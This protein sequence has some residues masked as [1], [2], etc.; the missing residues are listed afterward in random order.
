MQVNFIGHGL[1]KEKQINVGEQLT[2]SFESKIYDSFCGFIAFAAASGILKLLKSIE[3]AK[4]HYSR[5]TF[6]IGV[7]NKGTSKEALELLVQKEIEVYI[8]HRQEDYITYHPKLFL[9]EGK[10]HTRIILGS[11]NLTH[12][13]LIN[14][15]EASVQL[16]FQP[17]TDK[18]GKKVLTEVKNYFHDLLH[19]KSDNIFKL[20]NDLIEKY[21]KEG[22]LYSQFAK[23][24]EKE[25]QPTDGENNKPTD[26]VFIPEDII[27]ESGE[28]PNEKNY[29]NKPPVL[30]DTDFENFEIFL[31]QYVEYK[32][33]VNPTG[34][35]N[36]N[37]QFVENRQLVNWYDRIKELIRNDIL[38]LELELRLREVGFP[39]G[40]GKYSRSAYIW[41]QNFQKLKQYMVT[42]KQ[43]R[44]YV[45]QHKDRNHPDYALGQW[46]ARQK[47]RRKKKITPYF[48]EGEFEKL[49]SVGFV[50]ETMNAG[51]KSDDD[52]WLENYFQLE[53]V[54]N[55]RT[56]KL[57]L[58]LQTTPVGK[59]LADQIA[60]YKNETK[61][62]ANGE[63]LKL[64]PE[65]ASIIE[66][67]C[68]RQ[69]W[70]WEQYKRETI[71]EQQ[72]QAYLEFRKVYPDE[73]PKNGDKRFKKVLDW[74]SLTRYRYKGDTSPEN[75]WRMD[76][77]NSDRV[78][79][80]W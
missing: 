21:E 14:N 3:E 23:G 62:N 53:T 58:P 15:I 40:D 31:P 70:N 67:L 1:N 10:R 64:L 51:G 12:S 26:E 61:K 69:I 66:E 28:L 72:I 76:I 50:W 63:V 71:F 75:K 45:P 29:T 35:I 9:F 4:K 48:L 11:S 22:L 54:W 57:K 30:T 52:V 73:I 18:Q 65:R 6:F 49:Q 39:V 25:T 33:S 47:L 78:K 46:F 41:E 34:V 32:K 42:H 17:E 55:E 19:L 20:D 8:Y 60:N 16:D 68:G 59:W 37:T 44:A 24:K 43:T 13:G 77:L 2:V 74:K 56:D 36:D 27:F 79:F 5:L 38:P 80:P 7:D